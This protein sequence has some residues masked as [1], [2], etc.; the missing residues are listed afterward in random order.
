MSLSNF[1]IEPALFLIHDV[2]TSIVNSPQATKI[3]QAA[4]GTSFD[5]EAA[6]AWLEAEVNNNFSHFPQLEIRSASEINHADGAYAAD[7]NTIYLAAEFVSQ[8]EPNPDIISNVILEEYGHFLDAQFSLVD[9]PGD[10]GE[11][12]A[13]YAQGKNLTESRLTAIK[14]ENDRVTVAI[15]NQ[16][17]AIEQANPGENPAFDLIGLT[18]LRNDPQFAGIDGSG[19]SVV[20]IDTGIDAQHP[21][22]APNYVAGYD[23]IDNDDDPSDPQGHGTHVAG[24]IGA[25][26]ETIG[27]APDVGL[28][29]LRVLDNN[30][31]GSVGI[32]ENALEW[33][34]ENREQYNITAVNLSLGQ[35]FYTSELQLS[36]NIIADDI[37]RLEA[38]GITVIS[39]TGNDYFANSTGPD[40]A[41]IAFPAISSTIAVGA[42]WQ[43]GSRRNFFWHNGSIDHST[44]ADRIAS[45]SQRLDAPNV[46]FA[47]GAVITSTEPGG[48]LGERA[49]T[50]QASPHIAGAVALL[51]EASLQFS[52]RLLTPEEVNEILHTTGE[53][54]IDGDDEDDNVI[55]TNGSYI[56]VNVFNAISEVKRRNKD[57]NG[58][59]AQ[60]DQITD[61]PIS[62]RLEVIGR[63]GSQEVGERDVD[64]YQLNSG[65]SGIL[66]IDVDSQVADPINSV[67]LLFD[68]EGR[69]LG[70]NDQIN[71]NDS[72]LR[73]QIAPDTDYYVAVTGFG[74]QN[75]APFILGSGT[76]GDTGAYIINASL[77]PL[78]EA[79]NLVDNTIA[80]PGLQTI[81]SGETLFGNIGNDS[82]FI[83]GDGDVDLY[84]F[85][86]DASETI[87]IRTTNNEEFSAD[88]YLRVFDADGQEIAANNDTSQLIQSSSIQLEAITG[89]E[90]Y[91]GVNG[92]SEVGREY[93]PVT[94]EGTNPGSSG[95]YNL[96]V[97]SSHDLVSGSRIYRFF[98][99]DIGVHFYT[100]SAAERDSIVN[101]LQ[102]YSYEGKSYISAAD[103]ADPFT[104]A[105]PV[106]RFFNTSTGAHLYT[107]S[108]AERDNISNNLANYNFEGIAYYG[109]ESDR[110]GVIPLYRFYNPVVD[111]H[112]YTPSVAER[113]AVLAN[114]PDY[115]LESNDGIAFYVE[116]TTEI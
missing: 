47:P 81:I 18:K 11:L 83:V 107:M 39:A 49:G 15:D 5:S 29:G 38:A 79:G 14:A 62:D 73:F 58:S 101:N 42:V 22:I 74:N 69:R 63:D 84:R 108:E 66:E 106:Y 93:N 28:I 56:R 87:S 76:G 35:G 6:I 96:S 110:P 51:Q 85:V 92:N 102:N 72:L 95:N 77:R 89:R 25:A 24:T 36:G 21:L 70:I 45:F 59:I 75:F 23:F 113:D 8:N 40:P 41:N 104:G 61:L 57:L 31:A 2:L 33:V 65:E 114:L 112:F 44:G 91:I 7:N 97:S 20:V 37:Q 12:F 111:A 17:I 82:G 105:R 100:A 46:I 32:V 34:L 50:S 4:F 109:Y 3:L 27:V 64:F 9:T 94:G 52:G 26:D 80:S 55:N 54:I 19:F 103:T 99:S 16:L 60:A 13:N 68:G 78:S 43:D 90:Y 88:T 1:F 71:G 53:T 98:R 115:Q 48:G 116:P 30:G 86:P 67:I 10:E